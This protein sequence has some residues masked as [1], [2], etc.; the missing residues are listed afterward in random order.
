MDLLKKCLSNP[1]EG[2]IRET[3]EWETKVKDKRKNKMVDLIFNIAII[4]LM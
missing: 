4:T 1:Q 2:K 3:Q